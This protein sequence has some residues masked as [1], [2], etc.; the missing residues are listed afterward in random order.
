[1]SVSF[2]DRVH[3]TTDCMHIDTV[4]ARQLTRCATLSFSLVVLWP[5]GS[6]LVQNR[7]PTP[8][9][10]FTPRTPPLHNNTPWSA[11]QHNTDSHAISSLHTAH[12]TEVSSDQR[13]CVVHS[14]V[15]HDTNC[16]CTPHLQKNDR[17]FTP[18]QTQ[19][20]LHH[21]QPRWQ[22]KTLMSRLQRMQST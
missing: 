21:M 22:N 17:D 5:G 6:P 12:A 19:T 11:S 9:V 14:S 7:L 16:A 3:F 10:S 4:T 8:S 18:I 2:A 1:M 13:L 20:T 15:S